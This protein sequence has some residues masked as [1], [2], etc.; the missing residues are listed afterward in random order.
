VEAMSTILKEE[1]IDIYKADILEDFRQE[2][3]KQKEGLVLTPT[4]EYGTL[5]LSQI[6][7]ADF[8]FC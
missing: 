6:I 1:F 5:D 2:I 4:P 3:L 7:H 8:F